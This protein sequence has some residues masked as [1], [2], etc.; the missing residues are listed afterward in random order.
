MPSD[1]EPLLALMRETARVLRS[2]VTSTG[3][4]IRALDQLIKA[5]DVAKAERLAEMDATKA[6]EIDGA[7]SITVTGS[8]WP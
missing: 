8:G 2:P 1:V 3:D 5:A 7:S 4:E 6:H